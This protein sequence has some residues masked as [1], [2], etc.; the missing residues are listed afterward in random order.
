[1]TMQPT[2]PFIRA[3]DVDATISGVEDG[4]ADSCFSVMK[5]T[6]PPHWMFQVDDT[7]LAQTMISG[8]ISGDRG[9]SQ[10]LPTYYIPNGG[11]Y[12]TRTRALREQNKLICDRT[13]V[14]VM[15][16]ARSIDIDEPVD[17]V[18]AE[19]MGRHFGFEPGQS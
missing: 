18:V 5:V 4:G 6:Q 7:G 12:A 3:A 11:V 14:H 1:M 19:A 9:V 10:A 17:W 8:G 2:T 16:D 13:R 15:P